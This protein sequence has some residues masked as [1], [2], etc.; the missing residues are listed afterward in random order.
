VSVKGKPRKILAVDWDTK[1]LRVV[2]AQVGKRGIN[3]ERMLAV[4]IPGSVDPSDPQQMGVH[5]R[6]ALEQEGITTKQAIVDIPRDRVILN[7]LILPVGAPENLPGMVEIQIAKELPFAVGDAVIDFAAQPPVDDAPTADVLVAAIQREVVEQ[8]EETFVVAGLK[9]HRVGLRP[10]A[11]K[12]AVCDRLKHA[13]PRR[14]M[15]IDV[16]PTL[17]EIDI[18]RES[19]LVFSRAASVAVPEALSASH[20]L[21]I[22][23]DDSA[24]TASEDH[25]VLLP[26][27]QNAMRDVIQSLVV[28][29]TRSIEAYRA[30]DPGAVIEHAVIGGDLGVE[31]SL[32]E[33]IQKGL[34]ITAEVYNP[35]SSFGWSPDEGANAAAFAATLGLVLG[36]QQDAEA[37][38]DFLHPK[39]SISVTQERLKK[40]PL[41]AAVFAL[42]VVA[43]GVAV[44]K[45][46]GP[47]RN[48]LVS[49][50]QQIRDLER[51]VRNNKKFL[52]LFQEIREFDTHQYVWVDVLF[53]AL[54]L[55]PSH[56][57]FVVD[58]IGMSH[59]PPH[60]SLKTRAKNRETAGEVIRGL[61]A[62]RRYGAKQP[63]FKVSMGSQGEK[64]RD[65]YPFSQEL[66]ITILEDELT[67]EDHHGQ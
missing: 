39:R 12:V 2:H 27:Q 56:R 62:F 24:E 10:H 30:S 58:H 49:I 45:F 48:E 64:A 38:F 34:G 14:V 5:I 15:F 23:R 61:E 25:A 50:N 36:Q 54:S 59:S 32:A 65:L 51:N 26:G 37:H 60:L 66:R 67:K 22:V 28:E 35:A 18:I 1:T 4:A 42:F 40:A 57:E 21:S 29:V 13:L 3:I 19:S 33:A 44:A 9:L 7:T 47:K 53:D 43:G 55:F 31:E 20:P 16:R 17:T 41:V 11:H 52:D 63:R 8:Y 46:T 6:R